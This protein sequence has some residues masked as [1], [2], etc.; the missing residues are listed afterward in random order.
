M[1][2]TT[3]L[4]A[5]STTPAL[6]GPDGAVD[7]P[8]TLDD[9]IRNSL[10]FIATLRDTKAPLASPALTG[11]PTAPTVVTTDNSTTLATTAFVKA[12]VVAG[13]SGVS[14]VAG[15]SGAVTLSGAD[16]GFTQAGT[17]AILR[18][19]GA[20]EREWVSSK[21]FCAGDGVADDTAGLS[22]FFAAAKTAGRG[23]LIKGVYK[24]TSAINWDLT[25]VAVA[26]VVIEGD[27]E[28]NTI[29]DVSAVTIS[30][31]F[32]IGATGSTACFYSS[33][34]GFAI[35]GG[36]AGT[37][38][39]IGKPDLLDAMNE[40]IMSLVVNNN[41]P[42]PLNVAIEV[43]YILN[44]DARFVANCSGRGNGDAVK[45]RQA[46]FN[47]FSGSWSNALNSAHLTAGYNYGNVFLN[48]DFEVS[49]VGALIDISTA[50]N[51]TFLGGQWDNN[52]NSI[53]ATA[54]GNNRF[55]GP[56]FAFA[57]P[58][59]GQVGIRVTNSGYGGET[60]A[61]VNCAPVGAADAVFS[62]DA[63]ATQAASVIFRK[64][65]FNAW[66]LSRDPSG[67]LLFNRYNQATSALTDTP[68]YI[69]PSAGVFTINKANL[70]AVGFFGAGVISARPSVTGSR[71]G[72]PATSA[73]LRAAL[74]SLGL[75]SDNTTT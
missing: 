44:C 74:V 41:S 9:A 75:V 52:V 35:R 4:A 31:A 1:S 57:N 34:K 66:G 73:S 11:T 58:V 47:T 17:G 50:T 22:N 19:L 60:F 37:M 18:D 8:S 64:A 49:S 24:V 21:D 12:A 2:I 59:A 33:F 67:N 13:Q 16:V 30:P 26:G 40:F 70:P 62:A 3:T 46:A 43:N 72:E 32:F 38:L 45:L 5:C 65:G 71:G 29:I 61:S 48:P 7:A 55:V 56:N 25:S 27:G 68:A 63:L 6:N 54:G 69:E 20:K 39:R 10:S 28:N 14:S 42:S 53:N 51:N 36:V 15:R 23:R